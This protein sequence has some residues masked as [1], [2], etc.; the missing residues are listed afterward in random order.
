MQ[1]VC[2]LRPTRENIARLRQELRDPRYGDYFLCEHLSQF[3]QAF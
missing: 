2:F 1:A 3:M